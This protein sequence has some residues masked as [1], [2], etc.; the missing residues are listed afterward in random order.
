MKFAKWVFRLAGIYG[1]LITAPLYFFERQFAVQYPPALTHPEYYYGFLGVT[2]AW[3]VLF[4]MLSTDPARFRPLMLPAILEKATYG[5]A[6]IALFATGRATAMVLGFGLIDLTLGV[7]FVA[8]Y[9]R[10]GSGQRIGSG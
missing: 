8:A 1:V 5:P 10:T 9:V 7:L 4:L 2:L 3:Q 6:T